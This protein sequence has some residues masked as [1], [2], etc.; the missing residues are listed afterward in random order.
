MV[1][2]VRGK[3]RS[4]AWYSGDIYAD[5]CAQLSAWRE[6]QQRMTQDTMMQGLQHIQFNQRFSFEMAQLQA[7]EAARQRYI[8]QMRRAEQQRYLQ[9]QRYLDEQN[10]P[11][12][13]PPRPHDRLNGIADAAVKLW[14]IVKDVMQGLQKSGEVKRPPAP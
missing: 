5:T 4:M 11:T 14:P 1:A 9:Q 7:R 10:R 6:A 3:V 13:V 8:Q 12:D 2:Q